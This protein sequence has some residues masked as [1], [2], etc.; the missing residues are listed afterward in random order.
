MVLAHEDKLPIDKFEGARN[1][2]IQ[3][4]SDFESEGI[5]WSDR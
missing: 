4:K 3:N 1:W 2:K 5:I